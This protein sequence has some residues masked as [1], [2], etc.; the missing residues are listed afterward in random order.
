MKR[1]LRATSILLSSLALLA[2]CGL[3]GAWA[4]NATRAGA[5]GGDLFALGENLTGPQ[6]IAQAEEVAK[7][8][9]RMRER[10]QTMLEEAR[11]ERDI[12]RVTCLNDKLIQVG[13]NLRTLTERRA[14]LRDAVTSDDV[15]R[16]NHEFTVIGVLAQRFSLLGQEASQCIG[17]DIFEAGRGQL[18]TTIDPATPDEDPTVVPD[19]PDFATPLIPPPYSPI[20]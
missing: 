1:R 15:D 6:Q 13:A 10:I 3:G 14:S 4:Q 19:A 8:G 9:E 5:G 18:E 20:R 17:Q 11:R 12:I 2:L 7:G 16:R